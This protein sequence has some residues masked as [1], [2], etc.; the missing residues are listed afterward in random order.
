L[1]GKAKE[2]ELGIYKLYEIAIDE[3]RKAGLATGD[4][5]TQGILLIDLTGFS[6]REHACVPCKLFVY[7]YS[8]S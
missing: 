3:I 8:K 7:N 6:P 5:I 4:H 2:L 1:A